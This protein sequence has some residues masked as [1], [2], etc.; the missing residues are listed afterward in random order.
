LRLRLGHPKR[1]TLPSTKFLGT[2]HPR[3]YTK[4]IFKIVPIRHLRFRSFE[5]LVQN[6]S[7]C[8]GVWIIQVVILFGYGF[9]P[10]CA[11]SGSRLST[12]IIFAVTISKVFLHKIRPVAN[13]I[14]LAL[15]LTLS[16]VRTR[17]VL[18]SIPVLIRKIFRTM[19]S[20]S[21]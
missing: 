1:R 11:L 14:I 10:T 7:V 6:I 18:T 13:I 8:I 15:A 20:S 2:L 16:L 17:L 4:F 9:Q 12:T 3:R 21:I 5:T 19:T